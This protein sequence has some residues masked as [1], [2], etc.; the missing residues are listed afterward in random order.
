MAQVVAGGSVTAYR[1]MSGDR[2]LQL[3]S[4][5]AFK[6]KMALGMRNHGVVCDISSFVEVVRHQA[7]ALDK[8]M[9]FEAMLESDLRMVPVIHAKLRSSLLAD[10]QGWAYAI[11]RL[12]GT[13]TSTLS[14]IFPTQ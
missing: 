13:V 10:I 5:C 3:L 1:I 9:D 4:H 11:P 2:F 12:P 14:T 7:T 6:L 8:Q